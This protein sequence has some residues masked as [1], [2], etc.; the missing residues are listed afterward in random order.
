MEIEQLMDRLTREYGYTAR[1]AEIVVAQL[2][3]LDPQ[4]AT[5]FEKW[6]GDGDTPEIEIEQY[7]FERLQREQDMNPIA[8]FL[9]LDWLLREPKK[10]KKTLTKGHDKIGGVH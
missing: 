3:R 2:Q 1:G 9:T 5:E 6:W 7:T 10:A 8:A 4:L